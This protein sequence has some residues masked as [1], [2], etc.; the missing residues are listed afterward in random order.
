MAGNVVAVPFSFILCG[1]SPLRCPQRNYNVPVPDRAW[2]GI[3]FDVRLHVLRR[4]HAG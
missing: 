3:M 1:A 4:F 2:K